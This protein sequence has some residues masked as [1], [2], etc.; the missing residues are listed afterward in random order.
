MFILK[1]TYPHFGLSYIYIGTLCK[2]SMYR[3]NVFIII[4]IT[5]I[6]IIIFGGRVHC[7]LPK[8][9]KI[10]TSLTLV[11]WVWLVFQHHIT[12]QEQTQSKRVCYFRFSGVK[13][14]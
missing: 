1:G 14:T 5:I 13:F 6:I 11:L 4:I 9:F 2:S 3:L 10:S 8:K 7:S 12:V